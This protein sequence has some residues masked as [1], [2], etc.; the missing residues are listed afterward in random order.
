M[1][2]TICNI[3]LFTLFITEFEVTQTGETPDGIIIN[4]KAGYQTLGLAVRG[5]SGIITAQ[6]WANVM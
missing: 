2:V 5:S 3:S 6:V 1:D 4:I